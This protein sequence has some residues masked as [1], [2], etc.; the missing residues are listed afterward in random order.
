M[1]VNQILIKGEKHVVAEAIVPS[2][3]QQQN[4]AALQNKVLRVETATPSDSLLQPETSYTVGGATRGAMETHE[5]KLDKDKM[6]EFV[7]SDGTTWLCGPDTVEDVF[8]TATQTSRSVDGNDAFEIP[9]T[10]RGET[11]ERGFA[12]VVLQVVNVFAKKEIEG[13]VHLLIKRLA[14]DLE[15]KQLE[16]QSGLYRI[17]DSFA[18]Q[19][20]EAAPTDKPYLL[21]LHG[22]NSSTRGSFAELAQQQH[23]ATTVW[24]QLKQLYG[25]NTI[26]LQHETL[27][28]SPLQNVLNLVKQLPDSAILHLVS[29]SRGGLVGDVL[30]RFCN[31]NLN[32][33]ERGFDANEIKYLKDAGRNDDVECI[34]A[35]GDALTNKKI[36]VQKFIRV[37][38]PAAGTILASKRLDNFLNISLN[39]IGVGAGIAVSPV[40]LALKNLIAA[41]AGAKDSLDA[42]PGIEA[43][44]PDSPFIKALNSP[45]T[46][47][48]IDNPLVVI[49]GN[50]KAGLNLKALLIIA[51][52]LFYFTANDLVV[53]TL[54]MYGGSKRGANLTYLFDEATDV[55]HFH[56]FANEKT[57]NALLAAL[58]SDGDLITAGF[59]SQTQQQLALYG[60][61]ILLHPEGGE[62]FSDT[63]SGQKPIAVLLPGIMG[64]NL[65]RGGKK[66]WIDYGRFLIGDLQELKLAPG[67]GIE[68]K[69]IV[70]T[71]YKKLYDY[72]SPAY[73]VVTFAYDWRQSLT[74]SAARFNKK[75]SALLEY[76]QP[77]KIIG[78]SMGGVL[79]R[80]FIINHPDTW[81]R[82][83]ESKDFRLLFLG[84]PLGGSFRI[85]A[86]LF[87]Q[88]SLINLLSKIDIFHTKKD[89]LEFF[90]QMPGLW[91]LLPLTEDAA[92]DFTNFTT[93]GVW[94]KMAAVMEAGWPLPE[95][96]D[97]ADSF[98]RY[99]TAA[100]AKEID[101]TNAVYI[102]GKDKATPCGYRIDTLSN[103][104]SELVFL[105]TAEGDQSV[106][107]ESGI[108]KKLLD[109]GAVYYV[110]VSH[111]AL[112][113]APSVFDGIADI[114]KTGYTALLSKTRPVVRS[115]EKTFR[116]PL[117]QT[118]DLSEPGVT[119]GL[120][121]LED[122]ETKPAFAPV[123]RTPVVVSVRNG[124]LRYASFPVLA[125]HFW[126]DGIL[127]AEKQIDETL[128]K[129]LSIRHR[130]GIYPGPIGTNT[131]VL[132]GNGGGKGAII[133]GLDSF[134]ALTSFQL[135]Q[136]IEQGVAKYLLEANSR[137]AF[138]KE[139]PQTTMGI[140]TVLIGSGY[141][142]LSIENSVRAIV[143]GVQNANGKVDSVN[144]GRMK[145]IEQIEFVELYEDRAL[146]CFYAVSKMEKSSDGSF[147]VSLDKSGL[148]TLFGAQKRIPAEISEGWW[149]R[150]NVRL[151]DSKTAANGDAENE[152]GIRV[153]CLEF[154]LST[155]GA[156]EEKRNVYIS[157]VGLD[158]MIN[159]SAD[160]RQWTPQ[161][162]KT[163][164]ELL[165]PLDFKEQLKKQ[166][167][168]NWIVD[169]F[170]AG[171]PWELLQDKVADAKP[172]SIN[173]AMI[174]QLATEQYRLRINAVTADNALVVGDPDL[175]GFVTQLPGAKAE[176]EMVSDLLQ[177][178][179]FATTSIIR[180]SSTQIL[181][182]LY[183]NEY[184]IIHLAGHGLFDAKDPLWS[185][186]AIGKKEFLSTF[187][188]YQ[189]STVPELVFVNCCY[190]GKMESMAEE[191]YSNRYKLAANIGTQLIE[192]G[193]RA[194]VVAGWE[195]DDAAA[196]EFTRLF[197]QYMF[198]NYNFG[199]AVQE[200]RRNIYEKYGNANNTWGAYQAY[201]DPFYKF[202]DNVMQKKDYAP[203]FAITEEAEMELYNLRNDLKTPKY[204]Q[205]EQEDRLA[206][207]S[208]AVDDAGL[209]QASITELEALIYAD[210]YAY[211]RAIKKFEDVLKEEKAVFSVSTLE[212]YCNVRMKKC[213]HQLLQ[214]KKAPENAV[215][216][217]KRVINDL[218][219]LLLVGQTAERNNLL[220]SAYKRKAILDE[221]GQKL[222]DYSTSAGYYQTAYATKSSS[223]PTYSLTN[224]YELESVLMRVDA[225]RQWGGPVQAGAKTYT[226]PSQAEALKS[227]K[228]LIDG[229]NAA[230]RDMEYWDLMIKPNVNRCRLI[231]DA[232]SA[233]DKDWR[234]LLEMYRDVWN[235]AGTRGDKFAEI[236]QLDILL[237][238]LTLAENGAANDLREKLSTIRESLAKML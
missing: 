96:K 57:G 86:V 114:L 142:G 226:L 156:R 111:G 23:G 235:G 55:D 93:G 108:P 144:T 54:S 175:Q 154:S 116:A 82:L 163:L 224:W 72:L 128:D 173:G 106:T 188:I 151:N 222:S 103:G 88:D 199:T 180:G 83:N 195:V 69:S 155:G 134:G 113:A 59:K 196:L 47:V 120:L 165:V 20:F 30:S 230:G 62:L 31:S 75:I 38:C 104:D 179:E 207:I 210:M 212:K 184:K 169:K 61:G 3:D 149:Q 79:V 107:W 157:P 189:M 216:I 131:V 174:R 90:S 192:N 11:T 92:N 209:R 205:K 12:D 197:Y 21:F 110:N 102:A 135:I 171:Y 60:R 130:L 238:V 138:L 29:H 215:D 49:S 100:L 15:K 48:K 89:L 46:S 81:Q 78:H 221:A 7:F 8:P 2:P 183:S 191:Y 211:D 200:A 118:F 42:L 214:E 84:A 26:A 229:F 194:V 123:K 87:G 39:L 202:R 172:L 74:Q 76:A 16:N 237:D 185:G 25:Q 35:I 190:L 119:R 140:S 204:T 32:K 122:D 141:G 6:V 58:R 158:T 10:L 220:G 94:K 99:R 52:K 53:N 203:S 146:S 70:S 124:D 139:A 233:G 80:D 112:A 127:Y 152:A 231:V 227:L 186:M 97:D 36:I 13:E 147:N 164:F 145:L 121:G 28:K 68:A 133:V 24:A 67:D 95:M 126:G 43:M 34:N 37:A 44:N 234:A 45:G 117:P 193:V 208:R 18:L 167:N 19:K 5:V 77:I 143:Q 181:K 101:Y 129:A 14:A 63:V 22:T 56:Y 125:G 17:D 109:K 219:N 98:L 105:S 64:S 218:N 51:S 168:I 85:P 40:Y 225:G 73:D 9:R 66:L 198:A 161:L 50:C 170:T 182:A 228:Q 236:E 159:D 213:V 148:K 177:Q 71:S 153:R 150:I 4:D 91:D 1:P 137:S 160:K 33:E 27:T 232:A 201:G 162:A 166:C 65:Y 176:G 206:V 136:T 115:E 187:H 41:V 132:P 178:H 223:N 217:I